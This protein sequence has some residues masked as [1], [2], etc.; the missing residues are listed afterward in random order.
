MNPESL[1]VLLKHH[2]MTG[3]GEKPLFSLVD[4]LTH[5]L[6]STSTALYQSGKQIC[7]DSHCRFYQTSYSTRTSGFSAH[8]GGVR[9]SA[10]IRTDADR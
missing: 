5:Q 4:L 9:E 6:V 8:E 7:A 1:K 10:A 3:D 2:V